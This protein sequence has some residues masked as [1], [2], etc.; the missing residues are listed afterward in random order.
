MKLADF[1]VVAGTGRRLVDQALEESHTVVGA[2]TCRL[3]LT[4]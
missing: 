3:F 2:S 1:G 4:A